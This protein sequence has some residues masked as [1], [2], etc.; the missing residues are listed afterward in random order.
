MRPVTHSTG[1]AG[2]EKAPSTTPTFPGN[3]Q[4]KVSHPAGVVSALPESVKGQKRRCHLKKPSLEKWFPLV[5]LIGT[6][7]Y[8]K[9]IIESHIGVR[10]P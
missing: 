3:A 6:I 2:E 8:A 4:R 1:F 9:R 5:D 10:R 7:E